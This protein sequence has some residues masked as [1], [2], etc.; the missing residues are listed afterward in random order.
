MKVFVVVCFVVVKACDRNMVP[1]PVQFHTIVLDQ[2]LMSN[3]F[4]VL[5]FIS[6]IPY[7]TVIIWLKLD[8]TTK[9]MTY[10]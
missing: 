3:A 1:Y 2:A 4:K 9:C 10:V 6:K 5:D 8:L 7:F